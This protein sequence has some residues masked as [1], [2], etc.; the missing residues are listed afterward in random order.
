MKKHEKKQRTALANGLTGLLADT[1]TL[2]HST[3]AC[4]W[5]VAGPRFHSLHA[6]FEEQYRELA[7]AIDT[8]AERVRVLGYFT[9][10]TL[11]SLTRH[12][13]IHQPEKLRDPD[14]MLEHLIEAN[15]QIVHRA[16]EVRGHAEDALDE[17]TVDLLIER[18]RIHEKVVWMLESQAGRA[19]DELDSRPSMAAAS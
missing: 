1:Y 15:R 19:S 5:N 12:A 3:Q 11:Q 8:I 16:T 18:Q 17:A 7:E 6:M 2:Y 13:R 10:G 9:P 4:H 14:G